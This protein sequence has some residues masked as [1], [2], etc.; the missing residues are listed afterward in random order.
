V[1]P[2]KHTECGG[3]MAWYLRDEPRDLDMLLSKD[4]MRLDGTKPSHGDLFREKCPCCGKFVE[5]FRDMIR[6]FEDKGSV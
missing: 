5:R 3:V 6:C 2:I 1:V 4:Y